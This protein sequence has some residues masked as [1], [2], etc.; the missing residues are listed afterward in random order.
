MTYEDIINEFYFDSWMNSIIPKACFDLNN[1]FIKVN[2]AWEAMLGY[3]YKELTQLTWADIT[4]YSDI[5]ADLDNVKA[6]ISGEI[7]SYRMEKTYIHKN[8]SLIDVVLIVLRFPLDKSRDIQLFNV[9]VSLSDTNNVL[10]N[11]L[12]KEQI[13]RLEKMSEAFDK[14]IEEI[15][16]MSNRVNVNVGDRMGTGNQKTVNTTSGSDNK[17]LYVVLLAIVSLIAYGIYAWAP[18]NRDVPIDPPTRIA[19]PE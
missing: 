7:D 4:K 19:Q 12:K 10:I 15:K 13:E 16:N 3:S 5:G 14:K 17:M 8:G 2:K 6:M 1:R 18:G 9:Q 11:N